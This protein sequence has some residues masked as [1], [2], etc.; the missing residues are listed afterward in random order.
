MDTDLLIVFAVVL[1]VA[2]AFRKKTKRRLP[3]SRFTIPYIGTPTLLAK[4]RGVHPHELFVEEAKQL[5]NVFSFSVANKLI[6]VLNGFDAI[7]E[8]LVEK[9][10]T[11]S[12]RLQEMIRYLNSKEKERGM[13]HLI[14]FP[15]WTTLQKRLK[16]I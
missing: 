3:P 6:V 4:V 13:F 1:L 9:A 5:G 15:K 2:W 7:H 10:D 16:T 14:Y 8:A 11:C 12:G